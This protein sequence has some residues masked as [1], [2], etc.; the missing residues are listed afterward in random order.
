[1]VGLMFIIW[2]ISTII[3]FSALLSKNRL[4]DFMTYLFITLCPV[5]NTIYSI[6][7]IKV[8]ARTFDINDIINQIKLD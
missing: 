3:N 6:Y 8:K 1:M 2:I 5:V 7:V 4:P